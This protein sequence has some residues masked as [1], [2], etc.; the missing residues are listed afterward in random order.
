MGTSVA[1]MVA[2]LNAFAGI[3]AA[4]YSRQQTGAGRFVDVS[5]LD[6]QLSLLT[7]HAASWLNAH[8]R[9][10]RMGN[11]HPSICP[12]ETF[13]TEDGWLNIA[14]GNDAQFEKLCA[15]L[16]LGGLPAD[17][18]FATNAARVQNRAA[19]L[20]HLT[21]TLAATPLAEWLRRIGDA[22]VPCGPIH[23]VPEALDHPQ[24]AARGMVVTTEHP[25]AGTVRTV[26]AP[27]GFESPAYTTLPPPRLGEHGVEI[28]RDVLS[29]ASDRV[30]A[31]TAA[32]AVVT[33]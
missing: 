33:S 18:R 19:L 23:E 4:L 7:Y 6:G 13:A 15:A 29:Y 11:A 24:A 14:C 31:L 1:D 22:G 27:F 26:G 17:E 16:N 30:E 21:P 3:L 2:G 9:P 5:M 28:L 20:E 25:V 12:Y 8:Q 32:K 10:S